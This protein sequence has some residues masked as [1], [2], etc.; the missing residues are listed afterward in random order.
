M[1]SMLS[2]LLISFRNLSQANCVQTRL[3][4][5]SLKFRITC[6]LSQKEIVFLSLLASLIYTKIY[7]YG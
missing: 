7:N 1:L 3:E 6:M 2:M 4:L 5:F